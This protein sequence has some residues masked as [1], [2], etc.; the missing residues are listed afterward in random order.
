MKV[1]LVFCCL[2]WGINGQVLGQLSEEF[3][4]QSPLLLAGKGENRLAVYGYRGSQ[5]DNG[6]TRG[7]DQK[8]VV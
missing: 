2:W 8:S 1:I 4:G 5:L 3:N 6:A 7:E